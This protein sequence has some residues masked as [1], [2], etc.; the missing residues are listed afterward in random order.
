MVAE[1]G[2]QMP[3]DHVLDLFGVEHREQNGI[4][5]ASDVG[6]GTSRLAAKLLYFRS[7]RRIDVVSG[8]PISR[9][10]QP[11]RKRRAHQADTDNADASAFACRDC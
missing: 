4:A 7:F 8:K 6:N 10:H 5:F 11:L 9:G 3:F 2:Q 1:H